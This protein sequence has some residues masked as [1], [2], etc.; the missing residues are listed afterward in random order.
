MANSEPSIKLRV[1]RRCWVTPALFLIA[2]FRANW[3]IGLLAK[4][5]FKYEVEYASGQ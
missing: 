2:A 3:A 5:G 1:T 4:H